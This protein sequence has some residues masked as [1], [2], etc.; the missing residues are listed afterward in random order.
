VAGLTRLLKV[1][2]AA[3]SLG[4]YVPALVFHKLLALGRVVLFVYLMDQVQI[5]LWGLGAMIFTIGSSAVTLGSHHGITR[6]VSFYEARGQ[7]E[8]FYRRVR[9]GVSALALGVTALAAAAAGPL[10][11]LLIA[12]REGAAAVGRGEQ[13]LVCLLA[14]ANVAVMAL[15]QNLVSFLTGMRVYRFVS[16]VEVAYSVVFTALGA[17][18]LAAWPTASAAL[19]A[20][21][22]SGMLLVVAGAAVL[23]VGLRRAGAGEAAAEAVAL[24]PASGADEAPAAGPDWAL[25]P[26]DAAAGPPGALRRVLRFGAVNLL[27]GVLWLAAGYVSFWLASKEYGQAEAGLFNAFLRLGQPLALL[28]NAAWAVVFTHVARRWEQGQPKWALQALQTAYKGVALSVTTLTLVAHVTAPLWVRVLPA[29]YHR[30][31]GLV[32]GLLMFFQV[33]TNLSLVAMLA[34]LR[35]RPAVIA[36]T[37]LGGAAANVALARWWMP[38]A[39]AAG[40]AWAAGAGMYVGGTA[41]GAAYLLAARIRLGAG[42][43]LVLLS[44]AVLGLLAVSVPAA[45]GAWA[46]V[47]AAAVLTPWVFSRHEKALIRAFAARLAAM[48]RRRRA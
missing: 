9:L 20:H 39:G 47:L 45:A 46:A 42:T 2:R 41:V 26:P 38:A 24:A 14:L 7:L 13:V 23:Q 19:L 35:E 30:G 3:D 16:V 29:E 12:P 1:G 37:A 43:W 34:K 8:A 15:Y 10:T 33:V 31:L 22:A 27:G 44:P 11:D 36:L 17:A 40:A 6:Y 5:G 32:G 4:V 21:L 25:R 48:V 18:A 28:A